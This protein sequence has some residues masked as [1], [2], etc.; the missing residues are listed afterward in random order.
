MTHP[1][2]ILGYIGLIAS[3]SL[4]IQGYDGPLLAIYVL[5]CFGLIV[6]GVYWRKS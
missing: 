4:G 3:I 2:S 6:A 5:I 1:L